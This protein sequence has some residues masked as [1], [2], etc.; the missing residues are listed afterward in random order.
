MV[1]DGYLQ[2]FENFH[3]YFI[4][5]AIFGF[6]AFIL[7]AEEGN[8]LTYRYKPGG[9]RVKTGTNED[10]TPIFDDNK[11]IGSHIGGVH[12]GVDEGDDNVRRKEEDQSLSNEERTIKRNIQMFYLFIWSIYMLIYYLFI[13]CFEGILWLI[14]A[15]FQK[16]E[17]VASQGNK[18]KAIF[19]EGIK[20]HA[21]A[22]YTIIYIFIFNILYIFNI[23]LTWFISTPDYVE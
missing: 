5:I 1:G 13:Y 11:I 20:K 23:R 14:Y 2:F 17:K 7:L 10:G 21:K 9:P 16:K 8:M 22:I 6:G 3:Y 12:I 18:N 19:N 15:L 4:L